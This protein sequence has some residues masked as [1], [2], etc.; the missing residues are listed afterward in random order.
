VGYNQQFRD[1]IKATAIGDERIYTV[2]AT[3]KAV[4]GSF[5]SVITFDGEEI[6][7]DVELQTAESENGFLLTPV[8]DSLVLVSWLSKNKPFV[9]MFSEVE[10]V[11]LRGSDFGGLIKIEEL[12]KQLDIVTDR[13]DTLYDAINNAIPIPQDGGAG[14]QSTMKATLSTQIEKENY[15]DIENDKVTHG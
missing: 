12:T 13:L 3:V 10:S 14:L 7:E 1:S 8:I 4:E 2:Y 9:S 5:C 6:I 15:K 11:E